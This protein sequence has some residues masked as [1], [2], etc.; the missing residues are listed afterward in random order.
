MQTSIDAAC[1][2]RSQ[3]CESAFAPAKISNNVLTA[4]PTL[5]FGK[6][7]GDFD[8]QS[9]VSVQ[10]P[11]SALSSPGNTP[12]MNMTAYG[13]PILWNTAFQYH[14]FKYFWPELELAKRGAPGPQSSSA[15]ARPDSRPLPDWQ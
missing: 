4:Q 1:D 14:L 3:K 8:I 9:T 10:V 15:H 5:A 2:A 13:D 6:G 7:W 11:V 12:Q